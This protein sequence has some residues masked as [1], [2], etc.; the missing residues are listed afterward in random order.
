MLQKGIIEECRDNRG[1]HSPIHC[2]PKK[3]GRLRIVCNFK[4]TVNKLTTQDND[5]CEIPKID[6]IMSRIG[7]RTK[8][9]SCL[10]VASGYW[11]LPIKEADRHKTCFSW[12]NQQLQF[13]RLPFGLSF[14]GYSFVKAISKA[15][16]TITNRDQITTYIDDILIASNSY[17]EH[18]ETLRQL[19]CAFRSF[20]IRLG[21]SKC[22]FFQKEVTFMGRLLT[23]EGVKLDPK[24][25]DAIMNM[26]AP[27]TRNGLQSALG[28]FTWIKSW[29]S[30][31]Y[32]ENV[33]ENSCS[34]LLK[35]LNNCM[36]GS[37]KKFK[38]TKEAQ[39]A[40]A[41]AKKRISSDKVYAYA[42]FDKPFILVCDASAVA[43]GALLIQIHDK[44]QKIVAAASKTFTE[45]EQR[46]STS[47][48]ECYCIVTMCERFDYYLR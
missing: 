8:Y 9:F 6:L 10:D 37:K 32:N 15:L 3:S 36:K 1:W 21:S 47:E 5:A 19:L 22:K 30:A 43:M 13:K 39:V 48:R 44:K 11:M 23:P 28:N 46:W 18:L 29:L 34:Q 31:N 38:M 42:D 14:A 40:F 20:G 35:E 26:S 4:P 25:Y 27:T 45:C 12:D 2:V 7:T 16:N 24:N 33:A 41:T 17:D